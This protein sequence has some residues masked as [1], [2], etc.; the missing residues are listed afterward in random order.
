MSATLSDELILELERANGDPVR[1]ENPRNHKQYVIIP[2]EHFVS[3]NGGAASAPADWTEEQNARRAVLIDREIGGKLTASEVAELNQ[4]QR[5]MDEY[6]HR[7]APLPMAAARELH[8]KLRRSL[9]DSN[10]ADA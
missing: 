2:A 3:D 7:V 10:N 8:E 1:V 9:A 6:L 4:L 5:A